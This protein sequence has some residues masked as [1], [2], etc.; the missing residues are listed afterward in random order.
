MSLLRLDVSSLLAPLALGRVDNQNLH[1]A[2]A[3]ELVIVTH[4]DFLNAANRLAEYHR[5]HDAMRVLVTTTVQVYNEFSS[6]AQD[7]G[8][9]R[10]MMRPG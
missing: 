7:I 9:I 1:G 5:Q 2:D 3:P 8:G 6:G 4:P 10:D